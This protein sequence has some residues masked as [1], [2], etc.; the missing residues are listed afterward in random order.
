[1]VKNS[2]IKNCNKDTQNRLYVFEERV[3]I[4]IDSKISEELA[5]QQTKL[6]IGVPYREQK[7]LF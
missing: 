7:L 6:E 2:K 3:A 5:V 1:V 4:K